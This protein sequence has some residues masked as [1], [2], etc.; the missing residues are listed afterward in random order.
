MKPSSETAAAPMTVLPISIPFAH[1]LVGV[2][3]YR[4]PRGAELI[5]FASHNITTPASI[6][7]GAGKKL[8]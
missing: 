3:V 7:R 5:G 6:P 8:R 1:V 2:C 4:P